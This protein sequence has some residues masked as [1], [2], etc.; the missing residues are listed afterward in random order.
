MYWYLSF[1]RPPPVYLAIPADGVV[2]TPQV[3]ND[4]RTELRDAPTEIAYTWQRTHPTP[5]SPTKPLPLTRF[6]PP[7]STYRPLTVP[8]PRNARVGEHWRLGLVEVPSPGTKVDTGA[9]GGDILALSGEGVRVLGVWSEGI[10][11]RNGE[12][13]A[14]ATGPVR[15][16]GGK[17]KGKDKKAAGKDKAGGKPK[18]KGGKDDTP[19]QGRISRAWALPSG[20]QLTLVEQTSFDLDKKVWDSGL[21]LASWLWRYLSNGG[22]LHADAKRVLERLNADELSVVE[23]GSGTGLVSIALAQMLTSNA[24]IVA[25]DLES[26]LEIMRENIALNA[27]PSRPQVRADVLD[28]DAPLPDWVQATPPT[29]VIAA[30]VT[31]NTASFPSL[32]ATLER[33]LKPADGPAPLLLLAYKQRDAAERELWNML[34]ARGIGTVLVGKI[35]GAEEEGQVE[36]WVAG[37]DIA[38]ST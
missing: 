6:E 20:Q 2:V 15:G 17:D 1:L 5:S 27:E 11:L 19:K 26:A 4:L 34:A 28:W 8:L 22:G 3:A 37:A 36:M 24:N 9:I 35:R 7:E 16:V 10:E 12:V 32:V 13:V 29:V 31:Y 25:T 18:A 38:S 21:A 33:L 30:D 14:A 23:L